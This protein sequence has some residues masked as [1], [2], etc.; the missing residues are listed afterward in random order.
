MNNKFALDWQPS[1]FIYI[2][3]FIRKIVKFILFHFKLSDY[4][5]VQ[6]QTQNAKTHQGSRLQWSHL[7]QSPKQTLNINEL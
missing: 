2:L 3:I 1:N 7:R 6:A 4:F 5:F